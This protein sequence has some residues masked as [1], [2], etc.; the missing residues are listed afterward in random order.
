MKDFDERRR[1]REQRDRGFTLGGETFVMKTGVRPE[2]LA[3]YEAID[4]NASPEAKLETMDSMVLDFLEPEN[5]AA[6]TKYKA[7]RAIEDN[8]VTLQDIQA[9]IE[10]MIE[11]QTGRPT[12]Q[13]SG[14]TGGPGSTATPLTAVSS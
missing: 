7:V 1:E 2:V 8:P 9:V 14:S 4:V 3:A 10:W 12:G 11:A 6:L 5:G 13:P